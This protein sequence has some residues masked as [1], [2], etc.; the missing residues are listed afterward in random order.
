MEDPR[1][2]RPHRREPL[3]LDPLPHAPPHERQRDPTGKADDEQHQQHIDQHEVL[4]VVK[5]DALRHDDKYGINKDGSCHAALPRDR[6]RSPALSETAAEPTALRRA[7]PGKTFRPARPRRR[8]AARRGTR[9]SVSVAGKAAPFR[10]PSLRE[11]AMRRLAMLGTAA[12]L[13]AATAL[14]SG[15]AEG[16]APTAAAADANTHDDALR[17]PAADAG[18][19]PNLTVR[20]TNPA[21][22][23]F[24]REYQPDWGSQTTMTRPASADLASTAVLCRNAGYRLRNPGP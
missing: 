23:V 16:A 11:D 19:R 5:R 2:R 4:H 8:F 1:R 9:R 14:W 21:G 6:P 10:S 13:F 7:P 3:R 17:V 20:A 18:A 15:C 24:R 22:H 12:L